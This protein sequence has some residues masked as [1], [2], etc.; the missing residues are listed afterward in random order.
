MSNSFLIKPDEDLVGQFARFSQHGD[1]RRGVRFSLRLSPSELPIALEGGYD[2]ENGNFIITFHYIEAESCIDGGGD[3]DVRFFIGKNSRRLQ[4]IR[5]GVDKNKIDVVQLELLAPQSIE[6]ADNALDGIKE[7]ATRWNAK[8]N[9][10]FAD[11]L[12]KK[13]VGDHRFARPLTGAT[14]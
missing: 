8:L 4:Q 1:T 2:Q 10:E 7:N 11:A 6:K 12:L 9:Y 5:V 14:E 3:E 13:H